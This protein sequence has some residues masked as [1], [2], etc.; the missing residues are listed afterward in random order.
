M[1]RKIVSLLNLACT[2][3]DA[4]AYRP[5]VV[6]LTRRLPRWWRCDLTR[7]SMFLDD[8]WNT[9]YWSGEDAPAA[10]AAFATPASDALHGS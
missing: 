2:A 6:R 5:V 3:I 8:R 4:V 9:G 7:L 10:P 1:E